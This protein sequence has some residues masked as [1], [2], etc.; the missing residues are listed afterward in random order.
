VQTLTSP[1]EKVTHR[2]EWCDAKAVK[3]I[4]GISRST[5]YRLADAGKVKTSSL[6]ERGNLRGKR[7]F[8]YDSISAF[9]ERNASGGTEVPQ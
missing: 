5:L 7:L 2:P 4:F 6:R 8:N 3:S 9:I 1:T